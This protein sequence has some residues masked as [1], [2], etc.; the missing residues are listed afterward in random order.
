MSDTELSLATLRALAGGFNRTDQEE[1][2]RPYADRYFDELLP[3]W[4]RR[5]LD[6]GLSFTGGFYPKLYTQDILDR[7]DAILA[8]D[9]PRPVR[10]ILTE[11]RFESARTVR[12]RA[13]D[14]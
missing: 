8:G 5:E 11:Q 12:A 13:A 3:F 2:L 7:T 4:D 9:P 10:R 14:R 1:V 6:L